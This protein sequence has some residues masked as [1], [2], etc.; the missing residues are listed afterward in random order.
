M[1]VISSLPQLHYKILA[2]EQLLPGVRGDHNNHNSKQ[3][4]TLILQSFLELIQHFSDP[5]FV[6]VETL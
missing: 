2:R 4:H 3:T 1:F 5:F 6:L